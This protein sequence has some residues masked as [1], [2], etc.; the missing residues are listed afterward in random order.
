MLE[1]KAEFTLPGFQ[2]KGTFVTFLHH[3][4]NSFY[5]LSFP[6]VVM[7]SVQLLASRWCV[8][9]VVRGVASGVRVAA[10]RCSGH[11][12]SSLAMTA[13]QGVVNP[14]SRRQILWPP[15]LTGT[16]LWSSAVIRGVNKAP[17]ERVLTIRLISHGAVWSK[18]IFTMAFF[19][20][21]SGNVFLNSPRCN[22]YVCFGSWKPG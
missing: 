20:I 21:F 3:K 1:C 19:F 10:N 2:N 11:R 6:P 18:R 17:A 5:S 14:I 8:A 15:L 12:P 22:V 9:G 13:T 4:H 16:V 7:S